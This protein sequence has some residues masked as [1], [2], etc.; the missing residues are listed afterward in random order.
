MFLSSNAFYFSSGVPLIMY[1][2]FVGTWISA[3]SEPNSTSR[4]RRPPGSRL[5][6]AAEVLKIIVGIAIAA[7]IFN[8]AWSIDKASERSAAAM[9]KISKRL[10][11][12]NS[13]L[14]GI[15]TSINYKWSSG[16]ASRIRHRVAP[17]PGVFFAK[18]NER[19]IS[20]RLIE[21]RDERDLYSCD[22]AVLR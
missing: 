5:Q 10:S 1:V 9:D 7:G 15:S 14:S 6:G 8:L 11:G 4:V 16:S 19:R 18:K 21:L 12:T 13:E 22:D 20:R 2:A 3:R 17:G